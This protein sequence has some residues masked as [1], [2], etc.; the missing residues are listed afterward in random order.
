MEQAQV[1]A[2][3]VATEDPD[4]NASTYSGSRKAFDV[5]QSDDREDD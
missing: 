5:A 2:M 3:R 1:L 4:D